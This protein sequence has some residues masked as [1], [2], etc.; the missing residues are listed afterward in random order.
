MTRRGTARQK[1]RER[2]ALLKLA[3]AII[4]VA[5]MILSAVLLVVQNSSKNPLCKGSALCYTGNVE[6]IVDGDTLDIG[7]KRIRLALVNS[8]EAGEAG[9]NEAKTFTASL[10]PVGSQATVDE[11][12]G[13][14]GGSYGRTIAVVYCGGKNLNA[15]LLDSGHAV[16]LTE[17]C[18]VSEFALEDWAAGCR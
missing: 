14:T 12:D 15:E 2:Q 1:R 17:F 7:G 4:V 16:I 18:S 6:R 11:D 3:I 13:Q 9:Y 8:P 10:C 5:V